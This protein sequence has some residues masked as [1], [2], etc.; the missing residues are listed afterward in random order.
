MSASLADVNGTTALGRKTEVVLFVAWVLLVYPLTHFG[1]GSDGDAWLVARA[2]EVMWETGKYVASRSTGFPLHE[3]LVTPAVHLGG[4][5]AANLISLVAGA[6]L[7]LAVFHLGRRRALRHPILVVLSLSFLP[8]VVT[9]SSSTMDYLPAL[10]LMLWAY[11]AVLDGRYVL[12]GVLIGVACGFRPTSG[13][14]VIPCVLYAYASTRRLTTVITLGGV[15]TGTGILAFAP[16]L[17]TYGLRLPSESIQLGPVLHVLNFGYNALELFGAL[18][19]IALIGALWYLLERTAR[20]APEYFRT[21]HFQFHAANV[22]LWIGLFAAMPHEPEYLLPLVPS[23]V[24]LVDALASRR[25]SAVVCAVLLSYHVVG[26]NV[27]GG[28]SGER[29]FLLAIEPGDT[30]TDLRARVFQLS[31][32]TA[33][34]EYGAARPTVLMLGYYWIPTG[35]DRWTFDPD[36]GMYRQRS[37]ALFVAQP[38]RDERQLRRLSEAGFRLVVWNDAKWQYMRGGSAVWKQYVEVVDDLDGFFGRPIQ[39]RP[40]Q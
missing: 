7:L 20:S 23:V 4:W 34:T 16:V 31:T 37:G 9:N 11:A 21:P 1:Y 13:L 32:R 26:L 30:V 10:A 6:A 27:L 38:I 2:A 12:C 28:T 14:F 19:T 39:G 35:N 15:A 33:A 25:V 36:F 8:V 18:Q 22:A 5:Y 3:I 29:Q 40:A 17:V 24:L